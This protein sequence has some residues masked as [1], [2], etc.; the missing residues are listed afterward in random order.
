MGRREGV[1]AP[2]SGAK[3]PLQAMKDHGGSDVHTVAHGGPQDAADEYALKKAE[4]CGKGPC[5]SRGKV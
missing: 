2:G 1:G 5:W 4:A 3:V